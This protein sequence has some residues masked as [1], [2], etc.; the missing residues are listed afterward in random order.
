MKLK[1]SLELKFKKF[2][3]S[4]VRRCHKKFQVDRQSFV[5]YNIVRKGFR[6]M[7]ISIVSDA[8]ID[9]LSKGGS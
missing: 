3:E 2:I 4:K 8:R 5:A 6:A 1:V 7:G 9:D